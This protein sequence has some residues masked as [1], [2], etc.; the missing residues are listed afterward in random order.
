MSITGAFIVPH[1]PIILPEVGRGEEKKIQKTIDAYDEISRRI[2][3]LKPETIIIT[4]PHSTLYPNYFHVSP[5][6]KAKGD[7]RQFM[8]YDV[9]IEAEY[10]TELVQMITRTAQ[11]S[12]VPAGIQGERDNSL[13][14]GTLVPLYFI[15]K[16]YSEYKLVRIGLSR[17]ST[18]THYKFG[19][20]ISQAVEKLE[21][22]AVF[23][24][25]GDLSH[26]LLEDGPYGFAPEGP[27]FDKK[28]TEA[29]AKGDF[30]SFMSFSL[31]FCNRAAECG[32]RS[33]IIMAGAL[34][35]KSVK[36]ELLSYE[37]TFGVGYAVASFEITGDDE[38]RKF[39]FI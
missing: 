13:D 8:V 28:V 21:R 38:K 35:G 25:S 37:G 33:F 23:V 16:F 9:D 19:R 39:N 1:P 30:M 29:M 12:N 3:E 22:R 36:P 27:E 7:F 34:D 24:A 20:I 6:S 17:L 31:S 5:G 10:D 32:L 14:H 15:N 11:E 26:K 2:S 18:A 4:S